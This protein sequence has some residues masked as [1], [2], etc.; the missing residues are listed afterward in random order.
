MFSWDGII[1]LLLSI[2]GIGLG[3]WDYFRSNPNPLKEYDVYTVGKIVE[4]L[5][6][7]KC[8]LEGVLK[9]YEVCQAENQRRDNITLLIGSIFVTGSLLVMANTILRQGQNPIWVHALVSIGVFALWLFVVHN[10][11]TI[12]DEITYYKIHAIERALTEYLGYSF[13]IHTHI[14]DET[15]PRTDNDRHPVWWLKNRRKFWSFVLLL[16]SFGW[17]FLSLIELHAK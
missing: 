11:S 3:I 5:R 10:S 14:L 1:T 6:E 7:D 13:G 17:M 15:S 12:L 2:V 4:S 16:L 9:D 8:K